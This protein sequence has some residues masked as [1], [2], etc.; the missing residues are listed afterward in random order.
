M[1][2]EL[3]RKGNHVRDSGFK[4][5]IEATDGRGVKGSVDGGARYVGPEDGLDVVDRSDRCSRF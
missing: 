1:T 2:A 5:K 3:V 4:I